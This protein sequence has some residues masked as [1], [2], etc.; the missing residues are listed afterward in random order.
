MVTNKRELDDGH[1]QR[2]DGDKK[3][4]TG[5]E[6]EDAESIENIEGFSVLSSKVEHSLRWLK[7]E[8]IMYRTP[9]GKDRQWE[10]AARTGQKKDKSSVDAVA[11]IPILKLPSGEKKL[12]LVKQF[13]PP[14]G[15]FALEFPAG[16]VDAGESYSAAALRE[17]KEETGYEGV[18]V[19]E[20][21]ILCNS[22]GMT[23]ESI[24]AVLVEIDGS[25]AVNQNPKQ[26]L[27]ESEQGLQVLLANLKGLS[28]FL[29]SLPTDE[30]LIYSG[31]YTFAAALDVAH[32]L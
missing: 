20:S 18:A 28:G 7:L 1:T 26:K 30:V 29:K 22:P 10:S 14:I 27:E 15:R 25:R 3:P 6:V 8:S 21:S 12:V 13:R 9:D 23:S 24:V 16:L 17:L 5:S 19:G 32:L 4:K 2:T 31:L 11:C